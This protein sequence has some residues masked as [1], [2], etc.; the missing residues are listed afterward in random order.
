MFYWSVKQLCQVAA[1]LDAS[2]ALPH[3]THQV[4]YG[5][6]VLPTCLSCADRYPHLSLQ[7]LLLAQPLL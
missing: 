5:Q 1:K 2:S 4:R 7:L 3:M 6:G